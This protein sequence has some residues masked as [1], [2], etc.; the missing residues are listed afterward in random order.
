MFTGLVEEIGRVSSVTKRPNAVQL[1]IRAKHILEDVSVGDSIAVNGV[2]VTVS[3]FS[4]A[5]FTVDVMPETIKSTTLKDLKLNDPV[6][7]ERAMQASGRYGGHFMTG[8]VDSVGRIVRIVAKGNAHYL[9]IQIASGLLPHIVVKGS[10]AI[11]GTSLTVFGAESRM[12]TVSLIPHTSGQTIL[13]DKKIGD[14]V[15]IECDV[16]QRYVQNQQETE[17]KP[18]PVKKD[19]TYETLQANGFIN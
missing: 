12:L 10:V 19:L 2:C 14:L 3:R 4:S 13:G 5:A 8:H 11:D 6:N 17:K 9:N 7:L 18:R 16:L 1:S 15:N